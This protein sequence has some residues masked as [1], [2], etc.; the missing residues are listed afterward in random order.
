MIAVNEAVVWAARPDFAGLKGLRTRIT[1]A[2]A[3]A[4]M[5][6]GIGLML[7]ANALWALA[8]IVPLRVPDASATEIAAGRFLVYGAISAVAVLVIRPPRLSR[9]LWIMAFVFALAGNIAYYASLVLGIRLAGAAMAIL[10]VG[11]MPVTVAVVGRIAEGRGIRTMRLPLLAFALGVCLFNL[12]GSDAAFSL[13]GSSVLGLGCLAASVIMWTWYAI[14]NAKILAENASLSAN[15]WTSAVGVVS[16]AVIVAILPIGWATGT[17]RPVHELVLSESSGLLIW[18][19]V[20]GGGSTW[21]GTVIFN[22]AA[23]RLSVSLAGQLIIFEAV[24]GLSYVFILSGRLPQSVEVSGLA[25]ALLAVWWSIRRL[26][27]ER[28]DER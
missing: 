13:D 10:I 1:T 22:L 27:G 26:Q 25:I 17:I 12:G 18:S 9:R 4:P 23:R 5:L 14:K 7:I 3:G 15:A 19:L 20:L 2:A 21:L 6:Y 24:F 28:S 8:F 11:L 16:L